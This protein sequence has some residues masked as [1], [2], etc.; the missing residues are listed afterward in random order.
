MQ[1]QERSEFLRTRV[2][3]ME[4]KTFE[5]VCA[6][7]GSKPAE[8]LRKHV[9]EFIKHHSQ[10][11]NEEFTIHIFKP[12]D[13]V[14][15][16]DLGAWK[17]DIRLKVQSNDMP[18]ILFRFPKLENRII[19]SDRGYFAA[20]PLTSGGHEICGMLKDGA[21]T[22]H[23]YSNGIAEEENPSSIESVREALM[24]EIRSQLALYFNG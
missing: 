20:W 15:P 5:E 18:P 12:E 21:W 1:N 23:V 8:Q 24:H 3:E 4:K 13:V 11:L 6:A 14:P 7:I 2:T 10:H 9:L 22:G 19:H 16:Y 17:I